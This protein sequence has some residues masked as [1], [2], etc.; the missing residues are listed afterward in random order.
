M[1]EVIT[2]EVFTFLQ[3]DTSLNWYDILRG[4]EASDEQVQ[5]VNIPSELRPHLK[6][7]RFV[8]FPKAHL[9]IYVREDAHFG[10]IGP[11]SMED[12][13]V[14]LLNDNR[15]LE[16]T[17]FQE[18]E[19]R[20]VQDSRQLEEILKSITLERLDIFVELPNADTPGDAEDEVAREMEEENLKQ[21]EIIKKAANERGLQPNERTRNYMVAAASNGYVKAKGTT[22]DGVTKE[23]NTKNVPLVEPFVFPDDVGYLDRFLQ[24][25]DELRR[26]I[27]RQR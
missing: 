23:F 3:L 7:I 19:V 13:L 11:A 14:R 12:F 17:P 18:V 27:R 9:F 15:L 1:D 2:G 21:L 6:K 8:V 26:I 24:A 10:S 25:A 20:L 5:A 16:T 22:V 4:E